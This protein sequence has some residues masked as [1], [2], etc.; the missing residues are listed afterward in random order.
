MEKDSK[1]WGLLHFPELLQSEMRKGLLAFLARIPT[2]SWPL[3]PSQLPHPNPTS[4]MCYTVLIQTTFLCLNWQQSFLLS[5][6]DFPKPTHHT[7]SPPGLCLHNQLNILPA[8]DSIR[9]LACSPWKAERWREDAGDC[10]QQC[11]L[12]VVLPPPPPTPPRG[13]QLT[14]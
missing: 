11:F 6:V 4:Q 5:F 12:G 8:P 7:S 1:L 13:N 3:F 14:Y 10:I 2:L 9:T